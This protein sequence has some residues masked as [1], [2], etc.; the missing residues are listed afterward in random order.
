MS[1]RNAHLYVYSGSLVWHNSENFI[2]VASQSVPVKSGIRRLNTVSVFKLFSTVAIKISKSLSPKFRCNFT[3]RPKKILF[4]D[5]EYPRLVYKLVGVSP[6]FRLSSMKL[7]VLFETVVFCPQE[8][9]CKYKNKA[10]RRIITTSKKK[11]LK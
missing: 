3:C 1:E 10:S 5:L 8:E 11:R 4:F 7:F 9:N 2:V 6:I